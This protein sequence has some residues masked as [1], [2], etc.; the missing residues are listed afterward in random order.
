MLVRFI[1]FIVFYFRE[2][3]TEH[4][5]CVLIFSTTF[6]SNSSHTKKN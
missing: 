4:K 6:V 3:F 2:I 1:L 5:K